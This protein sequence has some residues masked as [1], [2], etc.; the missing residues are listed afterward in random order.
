MVEGVQS[1]AAMAQ[2]REK[3]ITFRI[4]VFPPIFLFSL[5]LSPFFH[6]LF[7]FLFRHREGDKEKMTGEAHG[8]RGVQG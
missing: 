4:L 7:S 6:P 5:S 1:Y 2:E 3:G 8:C